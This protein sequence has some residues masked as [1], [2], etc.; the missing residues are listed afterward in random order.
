MDKLIWY[1]LSNYG[2][3]LLKASERF[4]IRKYKEYR[5]GFRNITVPCFRA[6]MYSFLLERRL[7]R[8]KT[9]NI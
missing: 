5:V 9:R 7:C 3:M 8:I 2:I 1:S 6:E 4:F